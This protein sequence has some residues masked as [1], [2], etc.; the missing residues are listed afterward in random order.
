M[1]NF[2]HI[3]SEALITSSTKGLTLQLLLADQLGPHFEKEEKL[4]LPIVDNQFF[5]RSYHRQKAHLIRYAQLA[6]A[7]AA[8]VEVVRLESYRD[9]KDFQGL[10]SMVAGSS[11]SFDALADSL[12][13]TKHDN[14]GFCSN[15]ADW[16]A[17]LSKAGKRLRLEDFYRLQRTRL[18]IL[19]SASEPE[20]GKWNFDEEN[21]LPPPKPGLGLPS[22]YRPVEDELDKQ[23]RSELDQLERSGKATFIGVDGPR[24]FPGD[25]EQAIA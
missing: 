19:M 14:P 17:Y 9:L 10:T 5:K 2:W 11:R 25:R 24:I 1:A 18:G 7:R 21:R 12:N 20:G 8:N 23:V 22:P 13:L 4:L 3:P 6:R 16:S 15:K